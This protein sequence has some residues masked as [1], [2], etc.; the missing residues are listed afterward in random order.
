MATFIKTGFWEKAQYGFK[1]W[2]N[3]DQLIES[4][5]GSISSSTTALTDGTTIDITSAKN[6]LSSSS[7]TRTF[8]ISYEGDDITLIVTLVNTTASYT[9][10]AGSLCV[11]EGVASGD[12][13]LSL[14]GISGD[15]YVIGIKKVGSFYYVVSKNFGQ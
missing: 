3:L 14:T 2:L 10:P 9:F 7:S 8:T 5:A 11:S 4:I 12:N 15:K 6:T 13:V 1:G